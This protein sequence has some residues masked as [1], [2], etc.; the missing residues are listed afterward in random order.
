MIKDIP[1]RLP[2]L[3][4]RDK[5]GGR[6]HT[7]GTDSHDSLWVDDEGNLNYY[8]LQCGDGTGKNGSFEFVYEPDEGGYGGIKEIYSNWEELRDEYEEKSKEE[9]IW[10]CLVKDLQ[11]QQLLKVGDKLSSLK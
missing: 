9:L 11:I 5:C 4:I 10:Q 3:Q 1:Y 6:V 2:I 7:Y 8:N